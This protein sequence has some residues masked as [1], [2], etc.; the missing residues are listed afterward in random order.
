M[1]YLQG[2]HLLEFIVIWMLS[3]MARSLV[4]MTGI[5]SDISLFSLP[6]RLNG[7]LSLLFLGHFPAN[8]S[9]FYSSMW[10]N[11]YPYPVVIWTTVLTCHIILFAVKN[12]QIRPGL[13]FVITPCRYSTCICPWFSILLYFYT[14]VP[15]WHR[16]L[17]A[18]KN[19]Q[20]TDK[21]RTHI[22]NTR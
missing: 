8:Y 9:V 15:T 13:I 2:I 17:F 7:S 6:V 20:I 22:C 11:W 5:V 14:I 16:I 18:V 21:S 10:L 1:S 12:K 3:N 19:K 4:S